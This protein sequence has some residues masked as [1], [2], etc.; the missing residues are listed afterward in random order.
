MNKNL[1]ATILISAELI[2][3]F[4]VVLPRFDDWSA[5]REAH[6]QRTALLADTEAAQKNIVKLNQDYVGQQASINKILLALPR[7]KQ[8]DYLTSSLQAAAQQSGL[9]LRSI[10]FGD[11]AKKKG[12]YQV[13]EMHIELFG[14]YPALLTMLGNLEQSLRLY[15]V[16]RIQVSELS[17]STGSLNIT[18]DLV[19]YSLSI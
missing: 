12:E 8:L 9:E 14:R 13:I 17:G 10:S 7:K 15:D 5:A 2:L 4:L 19:A 3:F 6:T 18:L 1:F 11:A 16:S